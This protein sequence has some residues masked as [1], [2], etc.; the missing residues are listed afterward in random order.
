MMKKTMI[1]NHLMVNRKTKV[2]TIS[3]PTF[4]K[5]Q[6]LY[7]ANRYNICCLLDNHQYASQYSKL[8]CI[9]A[10]DA[11]RFILPEKNMLSAI[12]TFTN[13]TNDWIFGHISYDLKNEI[14]GL[15]S[16]NHDGIGFP[17]VYFFQPAIV[18]QLN[19]NELT[20]SSLT[21]DPENIYSDI[22][23]AV[24]AKENNTKDASSRHIILQPRIAKEDY[25]HSI[26]KIKEHILRGDCYELNYCQEFYGVYAELNTVKLYQQLTTLSPNP[27]ACYY[28]WNDRYLICASPE[29]YLQKKGDRLISQPI[30]GTVKR[31]LIDLQNDEALR[32]Y[33]FASEKDRSE[34]VMVVDLVRN[35]LSRVCETGTVKVD[36]L[37]GIYQFPQVYQMISTVSGKLVSGM[38]LSDILSA[39]FP[40]G[41][42]TGAPKLSVLQLIER[43]EKTKRGLYSGAVGYISPNKDFDFNVVIRSILYNQSNSYLSYQVGGGITFNSDAEKEYEECML[44]AEAINQVL[45]KY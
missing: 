39:S 29:R 40:M 21:D 18:L 23:R 16:E 24:C 26:Q 6:M 27:F 12:S 19:K 15:R 14:A 41:S 45:S 11:V 3:D 8:D 34:N 42:M 17:T 36:E 44:K 10:V 7:W 9:L 13:Q 38:N 31:D 33:L 37:F 35:D 22:Y 25:L 4:L 28:K 2:Y 1:F 32:K 30:K 43:Y 20:I 5:Q